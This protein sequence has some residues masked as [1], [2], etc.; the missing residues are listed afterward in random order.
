MPLLK[1]LKFTTHIFRGKSEIDDLF[2]LYT[3]MPLDEEK[4]SE[5]FYDQRKSNEGRPEGDFSEF[6]KELDKIFEEFGKA[7]HER[8]H[9]SVAHIPLAVSVPQLIKKVFALITIFVVIL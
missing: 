7:A 6:Y 5:F 3:S 9:T 8:R 2:D 1:M 4:P